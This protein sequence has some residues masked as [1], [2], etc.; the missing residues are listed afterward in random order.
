MVA[1]T[2]VPPS[3][4]MHG[5]LIARQVRDELADAREGISFPDRAHGRGDDYRSDPTLLVAIVSAVGGAMSVYLG[6]L[7]KV[8]QQHAANTIR[9]KS[10]SGAEIDVPATVSADELAPYVAKVRELEGDEL[11][12]T[13]VLPESD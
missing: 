4:D 1:I 5:A 10:K 8:A 6:G 9:V 2:F 13:L 7:L 11:E 12:A 3:T